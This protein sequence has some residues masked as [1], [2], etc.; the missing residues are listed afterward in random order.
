MLP[1]WIH[2]TWRLPLGLSGGSGEIVPQRG[3]DGRWPLIITAGAQ[4]CVRGTILWRSRSHTLSEG[5]TGAV[6]APLSL[7]A[8]GCSPCTAFVLMACP[9]QDPVQPLECAVAHYF[10]SQRTLSCHLLNQRPNKYSNAGVVQENTAPLECVP[11]HKA[12]PVQ[13][14]ART[15]HQPR[16]T[17]IQA[18]WKLPLSGP[19]STF[20]V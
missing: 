16:L 6:G 15:L 18:E 9:L 20:L 4:P 7:S 10:S 11:V 13:R 5:V 2:S 8:Q 1:V 3:H 12:R 19:L 17:R 14:Q